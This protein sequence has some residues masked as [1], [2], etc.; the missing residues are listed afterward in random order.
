MSALI[1]SFVFCYGGGVWLM[2][3][4]ARAGHLRAS[5]PALLGL[6]IALWPLLVLA[7]LAAALRGR[8]P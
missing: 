7:L 5:N 3:L 8:K 2:S 4:E 1:L 6:S